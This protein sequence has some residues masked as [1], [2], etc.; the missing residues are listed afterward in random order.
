[1]KRRQSIT[2]MIVLLVAFISS[3]IV[4]L[5][6][7]ISTVQLS[8]VSDDLDSIS[9]DF[10][11][12]IINRDSP[13]TN[14]TEIVNGLAT[15]SYVEK[16][17]VKLVPNPEVFP[18]LFLLSRDTILDR[19]GFNV[20]PI[21]VS[22]LNYEYFNYLNDVTIDYSRLIGLDKDETIISSTTATR[23]N[24]TIGD[25]LFLHYESPND[26]T[27]QT[28]YKLTIR[29]IWNLV[30][31]DDAFLEI[32]KLSATQPGKNPGFVDFA[33]LALD[34]YISF[35]I[36]SFQTV[37]INTIVNNGIISVVVDHF[38]LV[39]RRNITTIIDRY[40]YLNND[41]WKKV[42]SIKPLNAEI[43]WSSD[44]GARITNI[45]S[46]ISDLSFIFLLFGLALMF[47]LLFLYFLFLHQRY[48][49]ERPLLG[50]LKLRGLGNRSILTTYLIEGAIEG[51][52][53]G[54]IAN[55][56]VI[57]SF[58][59]INQFIIH[60]NFYLLLSNFYNDFQIIISTNCL[61]GL[62]IGLFGQGLVYPVIETPIKDL[63]LQTE[64]SH[65][66][67]KFFPYWRFFFL[68]PLLLVFSRFVLA[69]L[70]IFEIGGVW[71]LLLMNL[72]KILSVF[73][74]FIPFFLSIG[75]LG[76]IYHYQRRIERL[77]SPFFAFFL[78]DL[79][80]HLFR[81]FWRRGR[82]TL[83]LAF[84]VSLITTSS[85]ALVFISTTNEELSEKYI[86]RDIGADIRLTG[87]YYQFETDA[88]QD[89]IDINSQSIDNSCLF[90]F[91]HGSFFAGS[92]GT[93]PIIIIAL[94]S[95]TDYLGTIKFGDIAYSIKK[96]SGDLINLVSNNNIIVPLEFL[97]KYHWNTGEVR[98]IS[99]ST[100]ITQETIRFSVEGFYDVLPGLGFK[101][102]QFRFQKII[103][104]F[105]YINNQTSSI[106]DLE[107]AFLIRL[108]QNM[109][110]Q[111]R[112]EFFHIL[113]NNFPF[114]QIE[115]LEDALTDHQNSFEGKI[116]EIFN[117]LI[118]FTIILGS[119]GISWFYVSILHR[120]RQK[121]SINRSRGMSIKSIMKLNI[122]YF[123]LIELFGVGVGLISGLFTLGVYIESMSPEL[124]MYNNIFTLGPMTRSIVLLI[125]MFAC[126]LVM[127]IIPLLHWAKEDILRG[128]RFNE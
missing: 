117:V 66:T 111:D 63:I 112:K 60:I 12:R 29:D 57:G 82:Q 104:D 123:M 115:I 81:N 62:M 110:I 41:L 80:V 73:F 58:L 102:S 36:T 50:M 16:V 119:F 13:I 15:T 10:N 48:R 106:N 26:S 116:S 45:H 37:S 24:L 38:H 121:I 56:L 5:T 90:L 14:I 67:M 103:S 40:V 85:I 91:K 43:I 6:T 128:L 108:N 69:F 31:S 27:S 30:P 96:T 42:E 46:K 39:D 70:T 97:E 3:I 2:I 87:L 78:N 72:Q 64:Q 86:V 68:L 98:E 17:F 35:M 84:L 47:L 19:S 20:L 94:K 52:I 127:T 34:T 53:G 55:L 8:M 51:F 93:V 126:H 28:S 101:E 18:G 49:N 100:G 109:T 32:T 75:L 120:E 114:L 99:L 11:L 77:F 54:L 113:K 7:G 124:N 125:L 25:S 122:G 1:M 89:F 65:L 59:A 22:G 105:D 79:T 95:P 4:G 118:F 107:T 44:L 76:L 71:S 92:L 33:I 61:I 88:F 83:G 74:L 21:G 23:L 9:I